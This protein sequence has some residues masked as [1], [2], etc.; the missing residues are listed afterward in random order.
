MALFHTTV[1]DEQIKALPTVSTAS[2][3]IATF[4]T[5]MTENLV[6]CVCE[7]A[8]GKNNIA[9]SATGKNF[10]SY[11]NVYNGYWTSSS[12]V[13]TGEKI[14]YGDSAW[15]FIKVP[16]I[17]GDTITISGMQ[18]RSG[19]YSAFI[20]STVNDVIERVVNYNQNGTKT[21]PTGAKWYCLCIYVSGTT[22]PKTDCPNAQAEKGSSA[23][24]FEPLG[25]NI[26]IPFGETLSGNGSFDV[27]SGILTRSDDTTKQLSANYIQTLNGINNIWCNTGDT[28]VKY[29]LSVGKKIS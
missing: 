24:T 21:V 11:D 8:S 10:F 16:V 29:L 27:L 9:I 14:N 2:G 23:T 17:E 26:N 25:T 6:S 18:A 1:L 15:C 4:D 5:D 7:V 12:F 22:D 19:V 13:G 28:S 20:G 3:S